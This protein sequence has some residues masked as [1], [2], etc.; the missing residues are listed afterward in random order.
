MK[1]V[2]SKL[3]N[4]HG[5][6]I[7]LAL[8]FF[9]I[10][11]FIGSSVLVAAANNISKYQTMRDTNQYYLLVS[12]M[13]K[14]IKEDIADKTY[15]QSYTKVETVKWEFVEDIPQVSDG[16]GGFLGSYSKTLE[17][18][19]VTKTEGLM[20][21]SHFFILLKDNFDILFRYN[22]PDLII[23]PPDKVP[24]PT[25]IPIEMKNFTIQAGLNDIIKDYIEDLVI[26]SLDIDEN[27]NITVKLH[28][29][30]DGV[31]LYPMTITL[32]SEVKYEQNIAFV[33]TVEP[34]NPLNFNEVTTSTF[35]GEITWPEDGITIKRK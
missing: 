31:K 2:K 16:S 9:L 14:M 15:T 25:T 17:P 3:Q 32:P 26:E 19:V 5:V 18:P 22:I 20:P 33:T 10:C 23:N 28:L 1:I 35:K 24:P 6:S 12:S 7:L 27:F 11:S 29:L 21:D 4:N 13:A 8:L 34:S 30:V